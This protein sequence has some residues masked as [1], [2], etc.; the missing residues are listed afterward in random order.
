METESGCDYNGPFI[1][2][3]ANIVSKLDPKDVSSIKAPRFI[4][5]RTNSTADFTK[6]TSLTIVDIRGRLV[7]KSS[8]QQ[9]SGSVAG[10]YFIQNNDQKI[11]SGLVKVI[12][13]K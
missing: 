9:I 4:K 5:H 8:I 12:N 10:L 3:L 2:A 1:G 11:G 6:S 13:I 7:N